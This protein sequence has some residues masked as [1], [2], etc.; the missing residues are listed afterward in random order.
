MSSAAYYRKPVSSKYV[1]QFKGEESDTETL[2][3]V[4]PV[5]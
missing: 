2:G 3:L 4:A 5:Q 1:H